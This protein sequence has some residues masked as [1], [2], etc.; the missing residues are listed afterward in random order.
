MKQQVLI[1][2]WTDGFGK[3][4]AQFIWEHFPDDA[5]IIIT[6][7]NKRKWE[8]VAQWL[9]VTF[10]DDNNEYIHTADIVIFS[11]PIA[12]ME[13]SIKELAPK[14]KHGAIVLDVC[15]VKQMPSETLKQ[16]CPER[17]VIIPTHPMFGPYVST[18]ASQTIILSADDQN[19][20]KKAY[21]SF[22][23]YLNSSAARV[24]EATPKEHDTMMAVVQW[25]THF[26]LYV[27]SNTL[28]RLWV[29]VA[30]S[31]QFVSP[32]YKVLLSFAARYLHQNPKLYADIQMFNPEV[33]KVHQ[34]V[35]ESCKHYHQIVLNKDIQGFI[36]TANQ[37][38]KH[39]WEDVTKGAQVY[40]DKLIYLIGKQSEIA[41]ESIGKSVELR[42]IYHKESVCGILSVFNKDM[43][44]LDNWAQYHIDEWE[45]LSK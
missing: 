17:C 37:S 2:W 29:D 9:W 24:I 8:A 21:S 30:D 34:A 42:N 18:I 12:Y 15:S 39:F 14:I 22:K 28:E 7:R 31:L 36:D 19:K 26:D 16:Y 44:T 41:Q 35:I 33:L 4:M 10:T 27:V 38:K 20:K 23:N 11:V 3:W 45:I 40:T 13:A 6:G 32:N 1:L 43:L 25:L 5:D